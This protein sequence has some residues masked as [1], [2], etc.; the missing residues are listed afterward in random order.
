LQMNPASRVDDSVTRSQVGSILRPTVFFLAQLS[1]AMASQTSRQASS[2][3]SLS[4][5]SRSL[6]FTPNRSI[7]PSSRRCVHE[8]QQ[9]EKKTYE[10]QPT[11]LSYTHT[12]RFQNARPQPRAPVSIRVRKHFAVNDD[13]KVLDAMYAKLFGKDLGLS[14]DVKWQAVTHKSFDH[15]RQP[16][17]SKLRFL[18]TRPLLGSTL[19]VHVCGS[20]KIYYSGHQRWMLTL[21][22]DHRQKAPSDASIFPSSIIP[23]KGGKGTK[24]L[25][26]QI[27][28]RS[29]IPEPGA[30]YP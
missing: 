16:F 17:N 10:R 7:L 12:K 1:I 4:L 18:G 24:A 6:N 13:P 5:R 11:R 22:F 25:N 21:Y 29:T 23:V 20:T 3:L 19:G 2:L 8:E 26:L 27:S 28:G 30:I 14:G 9:K 15:G